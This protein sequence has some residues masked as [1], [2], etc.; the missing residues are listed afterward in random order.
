MAQ[1]FAF[2]AYPTCKNSLFNPYQISENPLRNQCFQ[3][4]MY[5]VQLLTNRNRNLNLKLIIIL[6]S[7]HEVADRDQDRGYTL[8]D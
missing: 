1:L 3:I 6:F 2:I 8:T 4:Y 7:L 5:Q